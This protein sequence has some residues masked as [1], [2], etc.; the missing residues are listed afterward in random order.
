MSMNTLLVGNTNLS[1]TYGVYVD[2]SMSYD[3]PAK[4]V[5]VISIPGRSGDLVV[6]YNT[7][8]NIVVTYPCFIKDNFD[9]QF[10]QLMTYLG[11][12]RGYQH[13]RCSADPGYFREGI[14]LLNVSPRAKRLNKDGFFDLSFNCKPQRFKYPEEWRA[15]DSDIHIIEGPSLWPIFRING[16]GT[17]TVRHID[18]FTSADI[19]QITITSTASE[20]VLVNSDTME[21]YT[22]VGTIPA[23]QYITLSPNKFPVL[24]HNEAYIIESTIPTN[25]QINWREWSL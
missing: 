18:V 10:K 3:T 19:D 25:V 5:D 6:D 22:E 13:I 21:C 2:S 17:V 14:P 1:T 15:I 16:A 20:V 7:F 12:L 9:V 8:Q 4:N 11:Y 24:E 23:G